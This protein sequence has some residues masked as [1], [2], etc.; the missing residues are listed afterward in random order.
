MSY[1]T[2]KH[3]RNNKMV[4]ATEASESAYINAE[5][6]R[7][8]KTKIAIATGQGEYEDTE[9]GKKLTLPVEIDGKTKQYRL[10]KDSAANLISAWGKDTIKWVGK[11]IKLRVT[12]VQGKDCVIS[13]GRDNEKTDMETNMPKKQKER[14][15]TT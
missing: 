8:S 14:Q 1:Y 11:P 2:S 5:L 15:S 7:N 6:V 10:N 9:Y 4:D 12:K 13:E 3:E